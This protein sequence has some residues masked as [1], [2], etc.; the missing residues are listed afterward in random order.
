MNNSNPM[1]AL[2]VVLAVLQRKTTQNL[3]YLTNGF[4]RCRGAAVQP[5]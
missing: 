1:G 2:D 3:T 5:A 4:G